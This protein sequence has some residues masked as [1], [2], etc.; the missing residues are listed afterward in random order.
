MF[1]VSPAVV[2]VLS[3]E[4]ILKRKEAFSIILRA[5][6]DLW[7]PLDYLFFFLQGNTLKKPPENKHNII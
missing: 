4:H 3:A 6:T 7:I 1:N 2:M 5:K